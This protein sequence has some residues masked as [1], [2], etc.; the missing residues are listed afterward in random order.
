MAGESATGTP[1]ASALPAPVCPDFHHAVELIGR[2]WTGAIVFAL[3]GGPRR[4]HE[5][6]ECV[7]GVSDR[8]LSQ[9]LRELEIEGIVARSVTSEPALSVSY[10]LTEKGKGL[11]PALTELQA[12]ARGWKAE[13]TSRSA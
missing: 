7:T 3:D 11:R 8:L 5:L 12:W 9:R 2:R 10:A 6:A 4:F 1:P 13:R